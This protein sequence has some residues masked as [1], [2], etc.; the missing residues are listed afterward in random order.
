MSA[1]VCVCM[2]VVGSITWP[3]LKACRV[4]NLA[5][6]VSLPFLF[7]KNILL[8][9]GRMRFLKKIKL[10]RTMNENC[11]V[12]NLATCPPKKYEQNV[13]RLLTLRWPGY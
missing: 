6:F 11:R 2:C 10:P 8:S 5:T 13:A 7:F 3:H 12:N 1:Y 4:N 9:V